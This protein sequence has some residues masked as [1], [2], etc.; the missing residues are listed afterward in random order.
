MPRL[1]TITAANTDGRRKID[2]I[3]ANFFASYE[4]D[5]DEEPPIPHVLTREKY[6]MSD[7]APYESWLLVEKI[8]PEEEAEGSEAAPAADAAAA[9]AA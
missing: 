6:A 3:V 2:N 7:E 8:E 1:G 9:D 5:D 4:I